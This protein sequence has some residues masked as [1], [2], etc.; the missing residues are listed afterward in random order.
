MYANIFII[1]IFVDS[2]LIFQVISRFFSTW[3]RRASTFGADWWYW[4]LSISVLDPFCEETDFVRI[5]QNHGQRKSRWGKREKGKD[6]GRK[7]KRERG[8]ITICPNSHLTTRARVRT[9]EPKPKSISRLVSL[10]PTF[11]IHIY[12]YIM[13]YKYIYWNF[14]PHFVRPRFY[15]KW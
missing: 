6:T 12:I 15:M 10:P 3:K 7:G 14:R 4:E 9:H 13:S 1:R 8:A 5:R 2:R 11:D